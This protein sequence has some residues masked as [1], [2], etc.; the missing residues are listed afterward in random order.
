MLINLLLFIVSIVLSLFVATLAIIYTHIS[1]LLIGI[2]KKSLKWT[3]DQL[4]IYYLKC[5]ISTD[6]T[7]ATVSMY[8]MNDFFIFPEGHRFGNPDETASYVFGRNKLDNTLY[9]FGLKIA[10]VL[11]WIDKRHVEKAVANEEGNL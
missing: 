1:L 7:G 6:Q 4:S 5:A 8:L 10:N 3:I 9:P 11:N 2:K